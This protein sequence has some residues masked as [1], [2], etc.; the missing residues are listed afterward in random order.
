[1]QFDHGPGIRPVP[2]VYTTMKESWHMLPF[3]FPSV[4]WPNEAAFLWFLLS[5]TLIF[6]S[7]QLR[8]LSIS[9]IFYQNSYCCQYRLL[10]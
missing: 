6:I 7:L 10:R 4:S 3:E 8:L 5:K 1:M 9:L 2:G